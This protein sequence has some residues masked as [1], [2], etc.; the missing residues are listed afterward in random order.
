MVRWSLINI[1]NFLALRWL[2]LP[3]LDDGCNDAVAFMHSLLD[4]YS[5][6]CMPYITLS[7][8]DSLAKENL[9]KG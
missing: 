4:A 9:S 1:Q 2:V 3:F 5:A 6:Q 7:W 8:Y